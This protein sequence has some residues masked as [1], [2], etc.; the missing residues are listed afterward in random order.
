MPAYTARGGRIPDQRRLDLPGY[1]GGSD[2]IG[3]HVNEQFQLDVFGEALL[4]LSAADRH[5]RLDADGW[6]AAELAVEAIRDRWQEK[7]CGV[8]EL[9]PEEWTHSRL[10]SAAGLRGI[11]SRPTARGQ[12]AEWTALADAIV[13]DTS[14]GAVH[15][16]GRWQRSPAD[17]RLDASLLLAALRGAVPANDPRSLA[18]LRAM[19][20]DLSEEEFAYRYRA[21]ERPLGDAEGAFVLCGFWMA[22]AHHQQ[23]HVERSVRWFERNR[24][25]CGPSGLFSEE[26]DVRQHQLRGN[27]PQAFVH[28]LLLECAATLCADEEPDIGV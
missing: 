11:A 27:L 14:Q 28:A 10:I 5:D 24:A 4:L 7:D 3:N 19:E 18:T 22:L 12:A 21:D 2:V 1:P 25:A 17:E 20:S 23:G 6:R 16:S 26:F 9:D 8:W 15:P 13:A